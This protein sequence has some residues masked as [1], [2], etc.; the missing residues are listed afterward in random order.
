MLPAFT[1]VD[2]ALFYRVNQRMDL[3]LNL[4]NLLDETIFVSG[5]VGSSLEVAAPRTIAF[6]VGYLLN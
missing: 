5:T 1:R 4:E 3:S 6:R 2:A